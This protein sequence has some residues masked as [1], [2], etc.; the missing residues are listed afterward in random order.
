MRQESELIQERKLKREAYLKEGILPYGG[1][2]LPL[3]P[4]RGILENF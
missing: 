2:F 4:I 3:E 1:R